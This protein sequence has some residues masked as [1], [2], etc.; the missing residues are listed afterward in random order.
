MRGQQGGL[1]HRDLGAP[2]L[3][4]EADAAMQL[5][6]MAREH[7]AVHDLAQAGLGEPMQRALRLD[8]PRGRQPLER[9]IDVDLRAVD[10]AKER[11]VEG[12]TD[13]RRRV[14]DPS[15]RGG[16]RVDAPQQELLQRFGERRSV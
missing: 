4:R 8:D 9:A 13:D 12:A 15:V 5:F 14:Q 16:Y 3:D 2:G 1:L 11:G 7:R 6:A 10:R